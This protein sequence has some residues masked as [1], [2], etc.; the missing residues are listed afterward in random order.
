MRRV[1]SGGYK[2]RDNTNNGRMDG[3]DLAACFLLSPTSQ[4]RHR[5]LIKELI[6]PNYADVNWRHQIMF[7]L[8]LNFIYVI[9]FFVL[10][11]LSI[12]P[13]AYFTIYN[14]ILLLQPLTS[15]A[16]YSRGDQSTGRC[17][18]NEY[19]GLCGCEV[20]DPDVLHVDGHVV[21]VR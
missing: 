10:H 6:A 4:R 2:K 12:F 3:R 15:F 18:R 21:L 19:L 11:S 9:Q 7:L 5:F 20:I 17:E 13:F 16:C 8:L 1:G 14:V